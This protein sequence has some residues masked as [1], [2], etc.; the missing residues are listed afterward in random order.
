VSADV[1]FILRLEV[2]WNALE[3]ALVTPRTCSEYIKEMKW[4]DKLS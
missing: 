1:V 2:E 4:V 3:L